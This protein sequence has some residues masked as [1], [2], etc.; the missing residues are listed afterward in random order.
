M[1]RSALVAVGLALGIHDVASA[2]SCGD[3][4]GV[5]LSPA[6]DLPA[7]LNTHVLVDAYNA[8]RAPGH[9]PVLRV[10]GG[11]EVP[12]TWAKVTTRDFPSIEIVPK[13]PLAP[14]TTYEVGIKDPRQHPQLFVFGAFTTEDASDTKAPT[15]NGLGP[16][17]V[18]RN[19]V[20][21]AQIC[22][23]VGTW[24]SL[25][26]I[27]ATDPG[28]PNGRM[29]LY[30]WGADAKGVVDDRKQPLTIEVIAGGRAEIGRE[31]I[32]DRHRGV[33]LPTSGVAS[34]GVAVADEAG[35]RSPTQRIKVDFGPP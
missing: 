27:S 4:E 1:K 6:R 34:L 15:L 24:L 16:V 23:Y 9:D 12:I 10:H 19:P 28:R 21:A 31:T 14:R 5:M 35:N 17:T 20:L 3:V 13:A 22:G 8:G 25:D 33:P 29:A 30:V 11:A 26:G 2:C 32:C 18:R 7:P